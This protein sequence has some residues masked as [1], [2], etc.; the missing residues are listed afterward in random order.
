MNATLK[1]RV[2]DLVNSIASL[3][4]AGDPHRGECDLCGCWN[5]SLQEGICCACDERL[6]HGLFGA[7]A[8]QDLGIGPHPYTIEL[9]QRVRGMLGESVHLPG[10]TLLADA[11][12]EA[13]WF[14]ARDL[15]SGREVHL[16]YIG[17]LLVSD[18]G[19]GPALGV[20][21]DQDLLRRYASSELGVC[22]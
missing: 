19:Q 14:A 13:L 20:M 17:D 22:P 16:H 18:E 5:N 7:A 15:R 9:A 6:S 11:I 4:R 1:F 21:P 8:P 2:Q 10:V 12:E 3:A